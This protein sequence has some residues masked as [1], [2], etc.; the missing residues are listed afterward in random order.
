[1]AC[2]KTN[3]HTNE[4]YSK[5]KLQY[6]YCE[7]KGHIEAVCLTKRKEIERGNR[8]ETIAATFAFTATVSDHCNTATVSAHC[9]TATQNNNPNKLSLMVNCGAPSHLIN[10]KSRFISYDNTFKLEK[11]FIKMADGHQSNQLVVA[12]GTAQFTILDENNISNKVDL[13]DVL[14]APTVPTSLFSVHA[15]IQKGAKVNFSDKKNSL[16]AS[17]TKFT[18]DLR[19][20]LHFLHT[21]NTSDS[22][23]ITKTLTEWHRALGHMNTK[24]ILQLEKLTTGMNITGPK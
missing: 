13:K 9:N 7:K 17:K 22:A 4:C 10:D 6:D 21:T 23:N 18:I 12:K 19:G 15:A 5:A 8:S 2:G 14:L 11:H 16:V 3:H 24:D 1:M 20:R